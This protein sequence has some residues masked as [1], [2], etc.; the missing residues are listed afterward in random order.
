MRFYQSRCSFQN[1]SAKRYSLP[2]RHKHLAI[3]FGR[4]KPLT[5]RRKTDF[6]A[7]QALAFPRAHYASQNVR[8]GTA[9][10][11]DEVS[12]KN[13]IKYPSAL[14]PPPSL[15][16]GGRWIFAKQKDGRR[17]RIVI[18][19]NLTFC[20][21]ILLGTAFGCLCALSRMT[22]KKASSAVNMASIE[23]RISHFTP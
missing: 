10:A 20:D 9:L 12:A 13:S 11:V 19:K 3:I 21:E 5:Y 6:S 1:D 8:R 4:S 7:P 17:A 22:V 23:F 18:L 2:Q 16:P 14:A 15:P